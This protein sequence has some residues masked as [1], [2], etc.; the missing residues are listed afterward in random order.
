MIVAPFKV[1]LQS[2]G[3]FWELAALVQPPPEVILVQVCR[4]IVR[5]DGV[6]IWFH[7]DE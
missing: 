3:L 7:R 5:V 2:A 4:I 6:A 1:L